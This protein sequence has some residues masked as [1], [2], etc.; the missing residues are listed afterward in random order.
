MQDLGFFGVFKHKIQ[1]YQASY[2][3]QLLFVDSLVLYSIWFGKI[4]PLIFCTLFI[5]MCVNISYLTKCVEI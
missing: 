1:A 4:Q 5:K 3:T 2:H